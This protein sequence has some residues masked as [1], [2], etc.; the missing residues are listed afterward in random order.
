V[1]VLDEDV[2]TSLVNVL[3]LSITSLCIHAGNTFPSM[4][5]KVA[6][7]FPINIYPKRI[8]EEISIHI[9]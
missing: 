3:Y 4:N 6:L 8:F 9:L 1:T 2:S 7:S 5:I